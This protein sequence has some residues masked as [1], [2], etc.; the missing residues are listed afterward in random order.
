ME[1]VSLEGLLRQYTQGAINNIYTAMP[2][3]VV[4]VINLGEG[5]ID[6]QPI[7]DRVTPDDKTLPHPVILS[8]PVVFPA[9]RTSA[10]TFPLNIND[11]VLCVFSQR[12]IQRFKL[13]SET[14][15]RP[16]NLAKYS[17]DDAIAI[18][19]LFSFPSQNNNPDKR[20]L[21]HDTSDAV[22]ATN[23]GGPNE[24]EVRLKSNGDV[25]INSPGKTVVNSPDTEINSDTV[26]VNATTTNFNSDVN[27]VGNVDFSGGTLV[28]DGKNI[29]ADHTH[30]NVESGN[31]N[32]GPVN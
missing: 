32:T 21:S 1:D 30:S 9:S 13:G 15:H 25:V 2:C 18:P 5:R 10:F 31:S 26:T 24:C 14:S 4:N 12:S 28:S 6:V 16:I 20:T 19:G 23:I 27:F 11:T 3:R 7:I 17:R 29:D 22:V 8:V